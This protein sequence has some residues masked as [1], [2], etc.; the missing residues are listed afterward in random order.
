MRRTA[1]LPVNLTSVDISA[2]LKGTS[3][4]GFVGASGAVRSHF[5]PDKLA[6]LRGAIGHSWDKNRSGLEYEVLAGLRFL[7]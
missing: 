7:F 1:G 3:Q 2:V 6:F 5:A 4:D